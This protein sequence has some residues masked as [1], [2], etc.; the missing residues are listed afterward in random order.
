MSRKT[1]VRTFLVV[2]ILLIASALYSLPFYVSKPGM[3]KELEPIIEV[4]GGDEAKGSFMLTT[5]RMGRANIYSYMMAKWSKYQELYPETSIRSEDETDE[6]YNIRQL[7]L[8]D[9]SKN[10]AIKIAYEKAGKEVEYEYLGVY[11]LDVLK[12]MPAA[13]ELKAG[14]QIIQVDDVKF[15]SAQ[16]FMDYINEKK[17]GDEVKIVYKREETEKTAVLSLQ[18]FKNDPNRVGIGISLDDNRR[19]NT[20]PAISIDSE[21]IGGPSA[22]LMFSLEIYNQL[23]K[24]DLTNGYDI[25][26][27]GTM[28]DDGTVGP[29]GGIQQKIVA[30]DKSGAE[31]FFA[32]N[33]N[34]A[35][36]SNYED[37]LIA[38]KD[39]DTDMKIVPVD[40]FEDAVTYLTKLNGKEK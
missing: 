28:S 6:E 8:M 27:T 31:I 37:A 39:I 19:V 23:T 5:V 7:H 34:G 20:K 9:G 25:A 4:S 1:Y 21:H 38:A 17:A 18:P 35:A 15:K 30:A 13:K 40:N 2:A 16:E 22:G 26:G 29:I 3:A 24:G 14:D 33:E 32:P 12:G 11:V 10:N 36:G